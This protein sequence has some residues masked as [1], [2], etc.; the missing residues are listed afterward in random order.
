MAETEEV[1]P[2]G[3]NKVLNIVTPISRCRNLIKRY[4][5]G[6]L[7]SGTKIKSLKTEKYAL[8]H[9][10]RL[11]EI[12][13]E[14]NAIH[15][16][17]KEAKT[18]LR[19]EKATIVGTDEASL[20]RVAEI[21]QKIKDVNL[22]ELDRENALKAEMKKEREKFEAEVAIIRKFNKELRNIENK[23]SP[24]ALEIKFELTKYQDTIDKIEKAGKIGKEIKTV[25]P[26]G[27]GESATVVLAVTVDYLVSEFYR[28][29]IQLLETEVKASPLYGKK[30]VPDHLTDEIAEEFNACAA[31]PL[32]SNLSAFKDH[33]FEDEEVEKNEDADFKSYIRTLFD[34]VAEKR[35]K[36]SSIM[37]AHLSNLVVEFIRRVAQM[38]KHLCDSGLLKVKTLN[39][40]H[41]SAIVTLFLADAAY[42]SKDEL[43]EILTTSLTAYEN[44]ITQKNK[45]RDE[46]KKAKAKDEPPK[47]TEVTTETPV[48]TE[49]PKEPT[50]P[51]KESVETPK[52]VT[53]APVKRKK[54]ADGAPRRKRAPQP[55]TE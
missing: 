55:T 40:K 43:S 42:E 12:N 48:E 14:I 52:D 5:N 20:K 37:T 45:K 41:V 34:I 29:I 9:T 44:Y 35:F 16:K 10:P 23:T 8:T 32:F 21:D 51:P 18:V 17:R 31:F 47:V 19:A 11:I 53:E 38:C 50:E 13:T 30:K 4:L 36:N 25:T 3:I 2:E 6:E 1:K 7:T 15:G 39:G 27:F 54:A 46:K 26:I 33:M 22:Q 28:Q 49:A 24:R